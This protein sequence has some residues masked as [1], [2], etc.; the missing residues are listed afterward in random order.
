MAGAALSLSVRVA[1]AV[2]DL[3]WG[4][5]VLVKVPLSDGN[6]ARRNM[7]FWKCG[8]Y[9]L[10]SLKGWSDGRI[11]WLCRGIHALILFGNWHW[12]RQFNLQI[13]DL[14]MQLVV[15]VVG[16]SVGCLSFFFSFQRWCVRI[17]RMVAVMPEMSI[18]LNAI[19]Q[20]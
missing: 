12:R 2:A 1:V 20:P 3:R 17:P 19:P 8:F 4:M 7:A 15:C 6:L 10:S 14:I 16:P 13:S 9:H 18:Q 11:G 5:K